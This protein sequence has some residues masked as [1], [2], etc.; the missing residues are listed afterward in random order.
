M[1]KKVI[2]FVPTFGGMTPHF[3]FNRSFETAVNW[4]NHK[5]HVKYELSIDYCTVG[6]HLEANRNVCVG[7]AIEGYK[8]WMPDIAVFLD[9]DL[10][11]PHDILERLICRDDYKIVGGMYFAKRGKYPICFRKG[12]RDN[13]RDIQLYDS[14]VDFPNMDFEVDYPGEGCFRIDVSVLKKLKAPYFQWG[15][16]TPLEIGQDKIEF[17]V[18]HGVRNGAEGAKFFEQIR[19]LDYKIVVDPKIQCLHIGESEIGIEDFKAKWTK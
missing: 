3:K 12:K 17:L 18:K 15:F 1:K 5:Y 8:Q 6:P 16:R 4:F 19:G 7:R 10:I 9:G 2:I 11:V 14:V 13:Y